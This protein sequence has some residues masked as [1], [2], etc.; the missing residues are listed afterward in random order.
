MA[1][2]PYK[3]FKVFPRGKKNA[4][5]VFIFIRTG[6]RPLPC[7]KAGLNLF[8]VSGDVATRLFI[9]CPQGCVVLLGSGAAKVEFYY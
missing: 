4:W 6:R 3:T 8:F 1:F 7:G 5:A 2:N 9:S